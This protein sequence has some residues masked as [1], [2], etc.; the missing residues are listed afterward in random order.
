MKAL[1]F[2]AGFLF[3]IIGFSQ[4]KKTFVFEP[5]KKYTQFEVDSLI[6]NHRDKLIEMDIDLFEKI[7]KVNP[8][9]Q[10]MDYVYYEKIFNLFPNNLDSVVYYANKGVDHYENLEEKKALNKELILWVY[11]FKASALAQLKKFKQSTLDYQKALELT[12]SF[13]FKQKPFLISGIAQNHVALGNDSLALKYY[14]QSIKDTF[15]I[16]DPSVA[17]DYNEIGEIYRVRYKNLDSAKHYYRKALHTAKERSYNAMLSVIYGNLAEVKRSEKKVDSAIFYY[18]KS[19]Q[20]NNTYGERNKNS[21]NFAR[22]DSSYIEIH[23]GNIF[24]AIE[25]LEK[26]TNQLLKEKNLDSDDVLLFKAASKNL[27][28]AYQLNNNTERFEDL[29][30]QIFDFNKKYKDHLINEDLQNLEV[31]YLTKEKDQ[32]IAQLELSNTQQETIIRQQ[33]IITFSLVGFLILLSGLGFVIWRQSKL[34]TQYEKENLEQRLLRL[35]MNPHFIGNAMNTI[36]G[37]VEKKSKDTQ[38]YVNN[39]SKLFRLILV[40]SRE[41]F[42]SLE[43]EIAT[44]NS[45]L[46]LESNFSK[47]FDFSF[48]IGEDIDKDTTVIPPML[49][50]PL[51]ENA[52]THGLVDET[53][54]LINIEINKSKKHNMLICRITDN[55]KGYSEKDNTI[56]GKQTSISGDIIRERIKILKS[57]FKLDLKLTVEKL[58]NS[59][60]TE[61]KLYLPY[62]VD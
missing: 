41:E 23:R 40:N 54:G 16:N 8:D 57:K 9:L 17:L 7:F 3:T 45:Y 52:I 2:I 46:L 20:A 50:Q 24:K 11:F 48:N 43:D 37:L 47:R 59:A 31:Q 39:L 15:L 61:A 58:D 25:D 32:S 56:E 13:P 12:N 51:I 60:G 49:I 34:K 44:I 38:K 6:H 53:N 5:D 29:V 30:S 28:L 10:G 36:N 19:I 27:A 4:E 62:L 22:I 18:Q 33:Q 42:V 26:I 14:L 35:Q 1:V 55:G 21:Y